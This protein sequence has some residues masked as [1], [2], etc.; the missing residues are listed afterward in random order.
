MFSDDPPILAD[1]DAVRIGV[2]FD[3][4][5]DCAGSYRVLVVVEAHQAGLRDRCRHRMESIEP[6]GIGNELWPLGFEHLPDRLFAQFRMPVRLGV[7]DALIQKPR[8][9]LVE[10]FEPQSWRKK[11]FADKADLVLDLAL[12]P[13]GC[14][15]AGDRVDEVMA[16]HLHEAAVVKTTLADEDCLHCGLHVVVDAAP[17]GALE[18]G[19]RPVMGVEHHLLRLAWIAPYKQH[20]AVAE[21]D[22]GGLHDHRHA[23]EQD[24]LMAP[25]KLISFSRRK[26]QRDVSRSRRLSAL[27]AP[28]SGVTAHGVV[29]TVIAAPAQLFEDPDQRK[30]LASSLGR[31]PC[32]QSVEFSCPSSQL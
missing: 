26:A 13:A 18:Q 22:M 19:E 3:R 5:T 25:V 23:I 24:D 9:Q 12:L 20:A 16:A 17:A 11:A 27:L 28:P 30:L 15:R 32:Q 7:G 10:G 6:A 29:T 21:P 8:I 31:I 1:H 4:T 2:N 14:R